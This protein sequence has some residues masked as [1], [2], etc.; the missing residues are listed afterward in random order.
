MTKFDSVRFTVRTD[1]HVHDKAP[2]ARVDDY[3]ETCLRKLEFLGKFASS[4]KCHAVLDNGDFFHAKAAT[5]N[6]HEMV[7]KVIDLHRDFYSCP[8]YE[9]PGNHDFPYNNIEYLDRQPLGVL[10]ASG[11]F[12]R[13]EDT[14]F[15]E[16]DLKVRVVGFPFKSHFEASEFN[17]ERGEEDILIVAAHTFATPNGGVLFG[18]ETALSYFDLSSCSPDIFIF[19]HL[20]T[21]QGIQV[22]NNKTFMNLGSMTRGSLTQDNL[23][24]IPRF[25][26]IEV[27]KD[28]QGIVK[29]HTDA[30]EYDVKPSNEV[31][32][33]EKS[34]R[35]ETERRDIENFI[36]TLAGTAEGGEDEDIITTI[37]NLTEFQDVVRDKAIHYITEVST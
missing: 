3:L 25:G 15:I 11:I 5:K 32:D 21:D 35:L 22:I 27:T 2:Q 36:A 17:I 10:F 7:R 16:G 33:L 37:R 24:R 30:I 12:K 8:V 18:H 13:M 9:N 23:Q 1:C 4:K 19:G 20:H 34:K 29:I 31:F 6:S 26:Y 14:T 28:E